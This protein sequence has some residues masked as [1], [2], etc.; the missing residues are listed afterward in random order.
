MSLLTREQILGAKL[1]TLTVPCPEWGGEV[2]V[3]ALTLAERIEYEDH[4][5]DKDRE[6]RLKLVAA[7]VVDD[8]GKR[9]FT[10]DDVTALSEKDWAVILRIAQAAEQLSKIGRVQVEQAAE[11]LARGRAGASPTA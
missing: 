1:A 8:D 3:Q 10:M 2:K 11:N 4:L 6:W 7:S 9:L 5:T